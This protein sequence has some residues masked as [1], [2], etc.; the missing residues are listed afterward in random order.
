M[1]LPLED[2][3]QSNSKARRTEMIQ[4][5]GIGF[6]KD[7]KNLSFLLIFDGNI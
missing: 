1:F 2:T 3:F 7:D 6:D 4:R 5:G